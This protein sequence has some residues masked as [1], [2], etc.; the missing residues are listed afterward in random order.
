[1]HVDDLDGDPE[2]S[3]ALMQVNRWNLRR[4]QENG[5]VVESALEVPVSDDAEF[6]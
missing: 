1:M 6:N 5:A 4:G 2:W 3:V